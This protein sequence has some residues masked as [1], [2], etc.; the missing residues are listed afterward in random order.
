[1][2]KFSQKGRIIYFIFLIIIFATPLGLAYF[3]I[4]ELQSN[5]KLLFVFILSALI[6]SP[7]FSEIELFG[8]KFKQELNNIKKEIQGLTNIV[9]S[10]NFAININ[11]LGDNSR[12][13]RTELDKVPLGSL[14]TSDNKRYFWYGS[15]RKRY[16]FPTAG[17]FNS[18]YPAGEPI[19]VYEISDS[20]LSSIPIGGNVTYK[21]GVKLIKLPDYPK[22]FAIE[23]KSIVRVF[24]NNE[25]IAKLY[26]GSWR[27]FYLD[28]IPEGYFTNYVLGSPITS[29]N[30]YNV[31]KQINSCKTVEDL[32]RK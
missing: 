5:I 1:M 4:I 17:T 15:D 21:P 25:I 12:V 8:L 22:I 29:A 31:E 28:I 6:L 32:I 30:D 7:L 20:Q 27:D 26:G 3:N 24:E 14:I 19:K 18:W 13:I 23:K 9:N 2:F 10:N 11:P 16:V